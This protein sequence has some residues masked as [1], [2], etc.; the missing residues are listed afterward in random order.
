MAK[1]LALFSILD[2]IDI[3]YKTIERACSNPLVKLII[4]NMFIILVQRKGISQADLTVDGTGYRLT[5]TKHYRS[6]REKAVDAIKVAGVKSARAK[7]Q[8]KQDK[9]RLF[10]GR[11]RRCM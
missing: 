3:S 11:I 6:V 4:H 1:L 2:D 7:P 10:L 5:I 9:R 8:T